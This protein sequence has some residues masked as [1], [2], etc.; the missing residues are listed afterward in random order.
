MTTKPVVDDFIAQKKLAVVGVSRDQKKFGNL[1]YREL[2]AKGYRVFPINRN[3]D[4]VEGD[5]CYANLSALPEKV[6]GVLIVVPPKETEQVV[7]EAAAAG[8]KRV[9]MQQGIGI[10][11]GRSFLPGAW[12][13]RSAW[14]MHY[15]VRATGSLIPSLASWCV[16]VVR[17]TAQISGLFCAASLRDAVFRVEAISFITPD[18]SRLRESMLAMT[19][20]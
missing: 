19:C 14:R 10:G 16:E 8:I 2:K 17:Q 3:V 5:R 6:E 9:W 13:Q 7:R 20:A 12:H 18:A 15:D 11:C 4:S 1:A